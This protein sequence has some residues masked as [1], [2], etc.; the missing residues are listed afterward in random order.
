MSG[1][2]TIGL[3]RCGSSGSEADCRRRRQ[4]TRALA[5]A[6]SSP[7]HL[8]PRSRRALRVAPPSLAPSLACSSLFSLPLRAAPLL[9]LQCAMIGDRRRHGAL[10]SQ[11]S[12]LTR[13]DAPTRLSLLLLAPPPRPSYSCPSSLTRARDSLARPPLTRVTRPSERSC[14]QSPKTKANADSC[15]CSTTA[16]KPTKACRQRVEQLI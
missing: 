3:R 13:G 16:H 2:C 4:W 12:L 10:L 11:C 8:S 15:N 7:S 1:V 5:V 14:L 9:R 6:V